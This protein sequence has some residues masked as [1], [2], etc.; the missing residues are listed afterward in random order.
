PTSPN[1]KRPSTK[2][3]ACSVSAS[4]SHALIWPN[5]RSTD[6]I[7][8]SRFFIAS[9][10]SSRS[11]LA[12]DARNSLSD[13]MILLDHGLTLGH[14][15]RPILASG[16]ARRP[17]GTPRLTLG[18]ARATQPPAGFPGGGSTLSV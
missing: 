16:V 17:L 18:S 2:V 11:F 14:H 12:S 13:T 7:H 15:E 9:D 3:R 6:V 1:S 8:S 10:R 5:N 4:T